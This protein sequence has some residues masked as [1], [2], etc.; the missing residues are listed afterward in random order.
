M[1]SWPRA[2]ASIGV[3]RDGPS[4][5]DGFDEFAVNVR[6][7]G[8]AALQTIGWSDVIDAQWR[9]RAWEQTHAGV[10]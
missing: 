7:A 8:I 5:Q 6:Q 10:D 9:A 3:W 1:S 4:R 2:C